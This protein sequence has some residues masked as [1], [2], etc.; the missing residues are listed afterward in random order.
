MA[1]KATFSETV[2][3]AARELE[4]EAKRLVDMVENRV[5]PRARRDSEKA[6]RRAARELDR[7]AD[8]LHDAPPEA[9]RK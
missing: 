7:L 2:A 1:N 6:L 8:R 5:V 9:E 4:S 3:Q